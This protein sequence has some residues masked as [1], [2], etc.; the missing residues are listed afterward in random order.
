[1]GYVCL[2][3]IDYIGTVLLWNSG[4][5]HYLPT[6]SGLLWPILAM[7]VYRSILTRQSTYEIRATEYSSNSD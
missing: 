1:M 4:H 2:I 7:H 3:T 5:I 6:F